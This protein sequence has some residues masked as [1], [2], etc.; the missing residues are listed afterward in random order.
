[1]IQLAKDRYKIGLVMATLFFFGIIISIYT[2]YSVPHELSLGSGYESSFG[3]VYIA[4]AAT[5]ILGGVTIWNALQY[6]NEV[7][8][9]REKQAEAA[10]SERDASQSSQTTI[11]LENVRTSISQAKDR[12]QMLH[13]G[14]HAICKQLEAGQGAIYLSKVENN[15]RKVELQ[16]G[17]ALSIGESATI[18]FEYGEGLIGQSAAGAKTVY[19]DE[20]PEG[21][22]KIISGLGSASPRFLLIVPM[23][24]N[25]Q[26]I[27]VM[28]I[29]SFTAITEDQRKFVEESAQLIADAVA[30]E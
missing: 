9:Y 11:S 1:M 22:I 13:T 28:E 20:V 17:Y 26:V 3:K 19:V 6:R 4:L 7:I 25:D 14:L 18:V 5:F 2:I 27:G 30:E 23:K 16:S 21:Y 15:I 12:R 8:V 10:T 24:R 29:A